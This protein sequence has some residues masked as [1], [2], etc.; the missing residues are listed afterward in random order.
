MSLDGSSLQTH[1]DMLLALKGLNWI[2][3]RSYTELEED[4]EK[5][6]TIGDLDLYLGQC[7]WIGYT[8]SDCISLMFLEAVCCVF[9]VTS[10]ELQ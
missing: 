9:E 7:K 4:K 2:N 5:R 10:S 3:D 6:Q 8:N 1:N